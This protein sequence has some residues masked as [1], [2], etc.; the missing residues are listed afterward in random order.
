MD[1]HT[2]S[3]LL[4]QQ[5]GWEARL[6]LD[7]ERRGERTVLA[8]QRHSGPLTVQ[9]PF[10]P[11]LDGTCHTYV[12]HPPGGVVGGDRLTLEVSASSGARALLTTPAATKFYR[13]AGP[14]AFQR[15][16]FRVGTGCR[17]E[18]LPQE[19]IVYDGANIALETRIEL[20]AGAEL[21]AWDIVCFGRPAIGERFERGRVEQR[22][23]IWRE[24]APLML[25]RGC[26]DGGSEVMREPFGLGGS[27]VLGLLVCVANGASSELVSQA[28]DAL[29]A[30][31]PR[32]TACSK[33][34]GALVCRYLGT[35]T[36]QA[37]QALGAA[38]SALRE[39]A[40]G[41]R[42]VAPRIWAT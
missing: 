10:H 29:L 24:G 22:L 7:F 19:S 42:A 21:L 40:F 20:A 41:V 37:R 33:L 32:Q 4:Q 5:L 16:H 12:L 23:E 6:E 17:L 26:Y 38:W 30:V 39:H 15:Q 3:V 34:P 14:R 1:G 11:E 2:S 31:A 27:P 28:R 9:R 36:E 25:E 13:T 8:R 18:W 35:S